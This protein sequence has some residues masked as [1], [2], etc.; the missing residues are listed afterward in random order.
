MKRKIFKS[1]FVFWTI[2]LLNI[3]LFTSFSFGVYNRIE[4]DY[5]DDFLDVLSFGV[6]NLITVLL[7]IS[8]I[9][10]II[11]NKNSIIVFSVVLILM[12]LLI[13]IFI[14]YSIFIIKDFGDNPTDFYIAPLIYLVIFG[15]LLVIHKFK[16]KQNLYELEIEEIGKYED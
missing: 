1:K 8:L 16:Y 13:S 2:L 15:I 4:S 3:F 14:F 5:F 11:K 6:I 10:S 9:L 12:L 7:F